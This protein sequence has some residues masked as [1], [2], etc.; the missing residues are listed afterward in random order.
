MKFDGA[1]DYLFRNATGWN[2]YF[3]ISMWVK[4]AE[5]KGYWTSESNPGPGGCW[6]Y[7]GDFSGGKA[8]FSFWDNS[9]P[10]ATRNRRI[11]GVSNVTDGKWH[12]LA[13]TLNKDDDS[14]RLYV[15]GVQEDSITTEGNERSYSRRWIGGVHGGCLGNK[16]MNGS[17]DDYRFYH[18]AL[19]G[20]EIRTL[21]EAANDVQA[22]YVRPDGNV[23]VGTE[24]PTSE[25]DVDG[26]VTADGVNTDLV[27]ADKG[28]F[29][30]VEIG[31]VSTASGGVV[32]ANA[33]QAREREI[34]NFTLN[35]HHWSSTSGFFIE[36]HSRYYDSG[37]RKYYIDTGYRSL[38][39]RKVETM[40]DLATRFG[41][42]VVKGAQVGVRS[43]HPEYRYHVYA[44]GR[45]LH[46]LVG[47]RNR[48]WYAD[49]YRR[50][51]LKRWGCRCERNL[52]SC[53]CRF[54]REFCI[55]NL[56]SRG[57]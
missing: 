41:I 15:D 50:R 13:V 49:D 33:T 20:E 17:V 54:A 22:I 31:E 6:R 46:E 45:V 53:K 51:C 23:G 16:V 37:Y 27:T 30:E 44:R 28:K 8:N 36:A 1:D 4:T 52:R 24:V 5:A 29:G 9:N 11:N 40:G 57:S 12:H 25:L 14:M 32:S 39:V 21:Y 34:A 35:D 19:T 42:R 55:R 7:W 26:V 38:A 2:G 18:R 48:G 43:G 56:Y 3:T 10:A 47:H